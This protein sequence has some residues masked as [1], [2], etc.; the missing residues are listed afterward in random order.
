ME[1]GFSHTNWLMDSTHDFI[2]VAMPIKTKGTSYTGNVNSGWVAGL[3]ITKLSNSSTD[4]RNED[5]SVGGS[6]SSYDQAVALG[7]AKTFGNNNFGLGV[8]YL[9]SYL[10]GEKAQG[11]AFDLGFSHGFNMRLPMSIGLSVQNLGVGL[12]YMDQRDPLPLSIS[13]GFSLSV[14]P[15]INLSVDAK[16]FVYDK[17]TNISLGTEYV[18]LSGVSLRSGYLADTNMSSVNNKGFSAGVGIKLWNT[19]LD[20][21]VTLYGELGNTQ[22]ISLKKQF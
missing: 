17:Q 20:Y 5:R 6:F 13:A 8:K 11:M 22:R 21:A 16:R 15:G 4:I 9:E 18:V 12:K 19:N 7:L 10:A 2:G 1:L 14:I 3:G